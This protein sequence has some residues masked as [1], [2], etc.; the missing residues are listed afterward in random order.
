MHKVYIEQL[1]A[2]GE[3]IIGEYQTIIENHYLLKK[4]Y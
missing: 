2:E 1:F 3:V 4:L